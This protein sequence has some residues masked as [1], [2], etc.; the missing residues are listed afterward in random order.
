MIF[1]SHL[2]PKSFNSIGM[3]EV[4]RDPVSRGHAFIL[5]K[6]IGNQSVHK[7]RVLGVWISA[8]QAHPFQ[9]RIIIAL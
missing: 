1:V 6:Y 3:G 8:C 9:T 5:Y 4:D 7:S 2:N